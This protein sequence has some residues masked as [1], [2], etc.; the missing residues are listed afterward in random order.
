MI[1]TFDALA[2]LAAFVAACGVLAVGGLISD[3]ILPRIP[4]INRFLD[5][6]DHKRPCAKK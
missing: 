6:L 5:S 2:A 4:A 3:L 1:H